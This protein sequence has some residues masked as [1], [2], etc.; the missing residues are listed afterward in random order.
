VTNYHVV[1]K[2]A[3]DTSGLQR[4]KVFLV[5]AKGNSFSREGKIIGF[6]PSY[7]LAVLKVDVEGYEIKPVLLGESKNLLVGQSCFA[8]GNPYGYENT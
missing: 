5:D 8:I 6:D 4:C 1:A 3:T 2:L 7:D